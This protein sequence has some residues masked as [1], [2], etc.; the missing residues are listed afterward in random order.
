MYLFNKL[1]AFFDEVEFKKLKRICTLQG[2]DCPHDFRKQMQ[3]AETLDD[4]LDTLEKPNY[5]NWLNIRLLKRIVKLTEIP[6]A[7]CLLDAYEKCLY[8]KKV[9]EVRPYFKSIYFDPKYFSEVKAKVNKHADNLFVS[10]VIEFCQTLES[11]FHFSEVIVTDC[12]SGCFKI[13][14]IIPVQCASYAYKMARENLFKFRK[15]HIQYLEIES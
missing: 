3:A 5:C 15:F 9:S 12:D 1:A 11:D 7:Q 2:G 14:C 6:E 13:T 8:S 4:I 10:D